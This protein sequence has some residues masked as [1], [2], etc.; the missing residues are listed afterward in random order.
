MKKGA[1][2]SPLIH[3][4]KSLILVQSN[5][6]FIKKR[7]LSLGIPESVIAWGNLPPGQTAKVLIKISREKSA[8]GYFG[9]VTPYMGVPCITVLDPQLEF[10]DPDLEAFNLA[11]LRKAWRIHEGKL[12]SPTV[13]FAPEIISFNNLLALIEEFKQQK[14]IVVDLECNPET[15]EII[16]FGFAFDTLEGYRTLCVPFEYHYSDMWSKEEE[17]ILWKAVSS[18]IEDPNKELIFHNYQF[19]TM[20]LHRYGIEV[21]GT[22]HDTMVLAHLYSPL[23]PKNL[24]DV[25]RLFLN[26]A[27]WKGVSSWVGSKT[28][29]TY[30]QR[31]CAYTYEVFKELQAALDDDRLSLYYNHMVPLLKELFLVIKEGWTLDQNKLNEIKAE[32]QANVD[33]IFDLVQEHGKPIVSPAKRGKLV[34]GK[35]KPNTVYVNLNGQKIDVPEGTK[36]LS[37]LGEVYE[38]GPLNPGSS[39]QIMEYCYRMGY[40]VPSNRKTGNPSVNELSILKILSSYP[41]DPVLSHILDYRGSSKILSTYCGVVPDED[42]RVRFSLTPG[43]VVTPRFSSK[44]TWWGTGFNAQN[45]PKW[46]RVTVVPTNG[47]DWIIW[48][49]DLK[50]ADPHLVAWLSGCDTMLHELRRKGG[51]LHVKTANAVYGRDITQDTN[52]NKDTSKERKL[53]KLVNNGLNY[54]MQAKTFQQNC[55][56]KRFILT[57]EEAQNAFD[58]YFELYPEVRE[59]QESIKREIDRNKCLVNPFGRKLFVYGRPTWKTYNEAMSWIPQGTVADVVNHIWLRFAAKVD[60]TKLNFRLQC[61]D[62][63]AGE[64]HKDYANQAMALLQEAAN[65]VT[66][67]IGE[68]EC[69]IAIDISTGPNMRD[70][71]SWRAPC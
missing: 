69:N 44:Q 36:K 16:C 30:N 29:F 19:D 23:L 32:E 50:Q 68:Y 56:Q 13:V 39:A 2:K 49:M 17:V 5:N 63:L 3:W 59:W 42:G 57:M 26:I 60:R 8:L 7:M 27:P 20:V 31:D 67:K 61:H 4:E 18:L 48:N 33:K 71:D 54:G 40:E 66:F 12:N 51:D 22:I 1:L 70:Q 52:Y 34:K 41:T 43:V 24:A 15:H 55:F 62:S 37:S 10:A 21:Q 58:K 46:F 25:A 9:Y 6:Y 53:G 38:D 64:V 14:R 65:E 11:A 47:K 35:P 28:L 45:Q